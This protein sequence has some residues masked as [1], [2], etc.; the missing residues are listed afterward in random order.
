MSDLPLTLFDKLWNAH[1]IEDLGDGLSLLHVDRHLLHDLSGPFSLKSLSERGLACAHPELTFATPDH[2]VATEPGRHDGSNKNSAKL[3]PLFRQ[4]CKE[5]GITLFDLDDERQGIV[6]V[7]G[8]E[9]GITLPG[10]SVVCGDSHTCTQGALG[11][12]AWGIGSTELTQVLA[13]QALVL[14]RPRTLRVDFEGKLAPSVTPK[15]LILHLIG[16]EGADGA[17]GYAVEFAGQAV[18]DMSVEGRLTLC[19]LAIEFGAKFGLVAPDEKTLEYVKQT[20]LAPTGADWD[21]AERDWRE[22][23]SDA[24]ATF[25][26]VLTVDSSEVAPQITWGTSPAHVTDVTGHVPNP[27]DV[28]DPVARATLEAAIDYMGLVP[29]ASLA[30]LAI[31]HVFIGSCTNSRISDLRAAA[32]IARGKSVAS[33]VRAWVVPGSAQVKR[34]AETEELDVIFK[35]AGFEWRE[36]GC[37]MCL[38]MNGDTIPAGERAI[39]TSNRNFVGRQGPGARTHLASP[40]M[41]AAAAIHGCITDVRQV[42]AGRA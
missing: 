28:D 25:D 19:N 10:V 14:E 36:P 21:R 41:A 39:S 30:G 26:R 6:H 2:A 40:A 15:D 22:L 13:T 20:S 8:P 17:A 35:Q 23:K 5:F 34:Q 4:G 7:V 38:G 27:S 32:A 24:G 1:V 3:M 33:G 18:R 12:L 9:Q 11:A 16:R 42:A 37:S 31:Q 29:K